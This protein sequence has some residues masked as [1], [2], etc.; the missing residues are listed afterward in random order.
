M[1]EKITRTLP[2]I[3]ADKTLKYKD[4]QLSTGKIE[5]KIE[6]QWI[7]AVYN[8]QLKHKLQ[9][10]ITPQKGEECKGSNIFGLCLLGEKVKKISIDYSPL[11]KR[12]KADINKV[13]TLTAIN[14]A[15]EKRYWSATK[16]AINTIILT[17][18]KNN[19]LDN[20][21]D[22]NPEKNKSAISDPKSSAEG[23]TIK[24]PE[25]QTL[26]KDLIFE[27][28]LKNLDVKQY[29]SIKYADFNTDKIQQTH[30]RRIAHSIYDSH[31][32]NKPIK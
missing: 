10:K 8:Y 29:K 2:L 3:L 28:I 31:A 26:T 5:P 11:E 32:F 27:L 23:E 25:E 9:K 15:M 19:N 6:R 14:E 20:N 30:K 1:Q 13:M 12:L 4:L 18:I 24:L 7:I 16:Y 22:S 21:P 17:T